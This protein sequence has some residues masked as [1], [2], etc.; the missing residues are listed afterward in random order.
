MHKLI[1]SFLAIILFVIA[2]P[3]K[4]ED[5]VTLGGIFSLSGWGAEGGT[6][7]SNGALLAQDEINAAGGILGK[8]LKIIL[9]D[10]HSDLK[11]TASAFQK[12]VNFDQVS[13]IVGPNWSEFTEVVSPLAEQSGVPFVTPTGFKEGLFNGKK[14]SFSLWPPIKVAFR[15]LAEYMQRKKFKRVTV[16]LTDNAY[17]QG[18]FDGLKS[19]LESSGIDT[20][21]VMRFNA[22]QGDF[23]SVLLKIR[24][25]KPDAILALLVENGD[26]FVFFKELR[27][28]KVGIPVVLGND[29]LF[30]KAILQQPSIA[31][32]ATFFTYLIPGDSDFKE[33]YRKRFHSEPGFGSARAYDAVMIIKKSIEKC[34]AQADQIRR[35]LSSDTFSGLTGEI[36]F[37]ANGN[38]KAP[39]PNSYLMQVKNGQFVDSGIE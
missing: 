8:P 19:Q 20:N 16:L 37:D 3:A 4:G 34:G 26:L 27:E 29:I 10:N 33:K 11:A 30:D 38:I 35:C 39:G 23:R 21:E 7:D 18:T 28:L 13:A 6:G 24:Q 31:N 14:F 1:I 12:L 17:L 5:F 22:G 36:S 32:G 2:Q 15:P 9:E 25:D